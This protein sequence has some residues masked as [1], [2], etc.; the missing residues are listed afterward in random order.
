MAIT[1]RTDEFFQ[2]IILGLPDG[3]KL[4][5][6]P[7]TQPVMYKPEEK[8]LAMKK[9]VPMEPPNSGPRARLIMTETKVGFI[10][11]NKYGGLHVDSYLI[12]IHMLEPLTIGSPALDGAVR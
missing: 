4:T 2:S 3:P 10:R 9:R 5:R 12:R 8:M 11:L 6:R 1:L 7:S